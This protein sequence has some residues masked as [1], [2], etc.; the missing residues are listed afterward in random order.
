MTTTESPKRASGTPLLVRLWPVYLI[1]GVIAIIFANGWHELLS[2][3]T[4]RLHRET[5]TGFVSENFLLA[6]AIYLGVYILATVFMMPGALWITIAGGFLFGLVQGSILTNIGATLGASTLFFAAR[7]AIGGALR[8][9]AGPF[10]QKMEAGFKEDALSYM[11]ALRFL[12]IMPYPVSNIAPALLGARYS[13]YAF[14]TF[15]G[16]IPALLHILGWVPVW[17]QLS[18]RV[19]RLMSLASLRTSLR[20]LWALGVVSLIPV[21]WKKL[22]GGKA[23]A[24]ST[25]AES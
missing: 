25:S 1:A 5:L 7:T 15:F 3:E 4:L 9:R 14:A 17:V 21:A 24:P 22:K 2:F 20:L 8:E 19:K 6:I 10:L 16:I 12:P 18:T 23:A 13:Q 11:F